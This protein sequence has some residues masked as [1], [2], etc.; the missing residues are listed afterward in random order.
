[1]KYLSMLIVLIAVASCDSN[2]E[3]IVYKDAV[4]V[5]SSATTKDTTLS[6]S[7]LEKNSPV[8]IEYGA[9]SVKVGDFTGTSTIVPWSSWWFPT[10]DKYLFESSTPGVLAPLQKYDLF[11]SNLYGTDPG[12]TLLERME[13]YNPSEVNWAGLCHA[14]A[15][16]SVLNIE[17]TTAIT[18]KD[19]VFSVADQKS[20]ILKS[21]ENATG[22]KI[23]GTRYNGSYNDNFDD[24]YPGQFHRFAQVFLFEKHL[25]F[26]MDYDPS[27]PVWTVPIYNI[28]FKIIKLDDTSAHVKAWVDIA[29][30][31]VEDPNFVGT[32]KS[33][34]FYEYK[35]IGTWSGDQLNVTSSEWINDSI[36]DHPDYVIAYPD[37]IKR[38]SRNTKLDIKI[39]DEIVGRNYVIQI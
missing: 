32:K 12:S 34:K 13:I 10:K 8:T 39:I 1:M 4:T 21:Y 17:P 27:F 11:T 38:A 6:P 26:L 36:Y 14:W 18:K 30:P 31:F 9:L 2:P 28:K 5:A 7:T 23:Y 35:L 22:L 19:I 15:M 25:P 37:N 3:K 33:T 24:I 20:L 29:T 16:A